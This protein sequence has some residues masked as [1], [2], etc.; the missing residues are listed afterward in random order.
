MSGLAFKRFPISVQ[1][2]WASG[3]SKRSVSLGL[4]FGDLAFSVSGLE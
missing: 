3:G 2:V 1:L 4:D